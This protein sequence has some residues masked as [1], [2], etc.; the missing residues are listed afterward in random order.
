MRG[1]LEHRE[2][3]SWRI[4]AQGGPVDAETLRDILQ[5]AAAAWSADGS[6]GFR[7]ARAGEPA[8]VTVSW[9]RAA[10][11][12]CRLF[13]YGVGIAHTGPV[14]PGNFVHL[15]AARTWPVGGGE[16]HGSLES[17]VAHEL[18][19]VLGLDHAEDPTTLMHPDTHVAAPAAGDL[20]GL[21]SLYG[22]GADGPGDVCIERLSDGGHRGPV[23]RAIAPPDCT[24]LA[25]FDTDGDGAD[26]LL[27]WR[28][29]GPG[30]GALMLYSFATAGAGDA[31]GPRLVR[32]FGPLLGL[33]PF[34]EPTALRRSPDGRR[35]IISGTGSARRV[36]G[37]D[38]RGFLREPDGAELRALDLEALLRAPGPAVLALPDPDAA[39]P[40]PTDGLPA[41]E[42]IGDLDGDGNAERVRRGRRR[43]QPGSL[44]P[45]RPVGPL[46]EQSTPA[47]PRRRPRGWSA[48]VGRVPRVARG[49]KLRS[50]P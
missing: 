9:H 48:G 16:L 43:G 5:S 46:R 26:E 8:D 20:A 27:A 44:A 38:N 1:R 6:V 3:L 32:S 18:G 30:I 21:H 4:E 49:R 40:G 22:G 42:L 33:V 11:D 37:F 36:R 50:G 45:L 41:A 15:D 2:A 47:A 10:D 13:G 25:L 17:A 19:H 14:G 12:P 39:R 29:D 23:L 28:T 7:P 34:G 31:A 35:W 24:E